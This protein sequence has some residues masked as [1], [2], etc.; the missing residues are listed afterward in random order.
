MRIK[1]LGVLSFGL[2]FAVYLALF[3]FVAGLMISL[4]SMLGGAAVGGEGAALLAGMGVLS[5]ILLPISYGVVGFIGGLVAAL[6]LNF[7]FRLTGGLE[8]DL[9]H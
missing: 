6:F 7:A 8:L 9:E 5:I 2:N 3:G 1:R 4:V